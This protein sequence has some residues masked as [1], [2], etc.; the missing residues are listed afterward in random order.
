VYKLEESGWDPSDKV[1]AFDLSLSTF[2]ELTCTPESCRVPIGVFYKEDGR[3]TYEDGLP[4][5]QIAGFRRAETPR[6]VT[7]LF[8]ALS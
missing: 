2:H 6:D 1:K 3:P 5:A 8:D 4:A 7:P